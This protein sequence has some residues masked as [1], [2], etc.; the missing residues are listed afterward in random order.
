MERKEITALLSSAAQ[1]VNQ[2]NQMLLAI[3]KFVGEPVDPVPFEKKP[4]EPKSAP[5]VK[6]M[7]T[8]DEAVA[9]LGLKSRMAI[10]HMVNSGRIARYGSGRRS[11][12]K[13]AELEEY[14]LGRKKSSSRE[15]SEQADAV[16][17]RRGK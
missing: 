13:R 4:Q 17:N 6:D 14:M 9:F 7:L 5:I 1:L 12:F 10:Y 2:A 3:S 11:Y 8:T 16:L 15:I